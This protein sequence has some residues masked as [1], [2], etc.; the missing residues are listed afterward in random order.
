M[1]GRE[2]RPITATACDKQYFLAWSPGSLTKGSKARW[3]T[4]LPVL[5]LVNNCKVLWRMHQRFSAILPWINCSPPGPSD[6]EHSRAREPGSIFS[7]TKLSFFPRTQLKISWGWSTNTFSSSKCHAIIN[8]GKSR[9]YT[10]DPF[11]NM[12]LPTKSSKLA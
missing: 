7:Y 11:E 3:N 9:I 4:N 5:W 10:Q 2:E 8:H 1:R 6:A 12:L